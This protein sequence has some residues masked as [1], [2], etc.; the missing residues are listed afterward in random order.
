METI[1]TNSE[2]STAIIADALKSQHH[3]TYDQ[4][5]PERGRIDGQ[6]D[7][8]IFDIEGLGNIGSVRTIKHIYYCD[9]EATFNKNDE[10]LIASCMNVLAAEVHRK[11]INKL[12][13]LDYCL[14]YVMH[15]TCLVTITRETDIEQSIDK[16]RVTIE[17]RAFLALKPNY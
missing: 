11:S 5:R 7:V 2:Y 16:L 14:N 12:S 1:Y 15:P 13:A 17:A 4:D 3:K 9:Y 10:L 8:R 6:I